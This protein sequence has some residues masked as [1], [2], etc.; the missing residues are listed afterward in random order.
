MTSQLQ[1]E[2]PGSSLERPVDA[3][4]RRQNEADKAKQQAALAIA[5]AMPFV[6]GVL[7]ECL[8]DEDRQVRLRAADILLSRSIPKIAAKHIEEDPSTVKDSAD[9]AALRDSILDEIRK[10]R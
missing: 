10:R 1:P 5:Q 7:M 2:R 3:L 8:T 6:V 9:T 4:A